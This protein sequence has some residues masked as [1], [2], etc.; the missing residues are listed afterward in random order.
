MAS[1]F[2]VVS[3]LL[4]LDISI[5]KCPTPSRF[6]GSSLPPI[7]GSLTPPLES[8]LR[9]HLQRAH[10]HSFF[11]PPLSQWPPDW[12]PCLPSPT[13]YPFLLEFVKSDQIPLLPKSFSFLFC[14]QSG[15]SSLCLCPFFPS[16][17]TLTPQTSHLY[18]K[19]NHALPASP[20]NWHLPSTSTRI[21]LWAA[22]A[23]DL[24][25]LLKGVQGGGQEWGT[26]CS[27]KKLAE[28]VF[29]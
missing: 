7:P 8:P 9:K 2:L 14:F 27:G 24:Q 26:L 29:R 4:D 13:P 23:A 12:F 20:T 28:Q 22:A 16:S 3:T 6:S 5:L 11:S 25:H 1:D 10:Y 17:S 18:P 21:K 15:F 19:V